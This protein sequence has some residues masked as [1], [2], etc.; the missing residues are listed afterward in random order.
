MKKNIAKLA[1]IAVLSGSMTIISLGTAM[2]ADSV[3][4]GTTGPSSINSVNVSD[5][6]DFAQINTNT[7]VI[8]NISSQSAMTGDASVNGN[9]NAGSAT[10]GAATNNSVVQTAV[11]ISNGSGL[12]LPVGGSSGG[13]GSGAG[14]PGSGV[15]APLAGGS[16]AGQLAYGGM[17]GGLLPVT[18]PSDI[19]DV[20]AMRQLYKPMSEITPVA[21]PIV[22]QVKHIST[23]LL[24]GALLL[25]IIGTLGSVMY[26]GK[27]SERV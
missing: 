1:Q 9:T 8:T 17:G 7:V 21:G 12:V 23:S 4:V 11:T 14:L 25:T 24:L 26:A 18:G 20:S 6:Y 27:R 16:G 22:T 3:N 10:T 19:V 5:S 2:A 13:R 15:S